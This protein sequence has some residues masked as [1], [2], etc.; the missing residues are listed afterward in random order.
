[1][2]GSEES[3]APGSLVL[4]VLCPSIPAPNRFTFDN[5]SLNTTVAEL[6]ARLSRSIQ[7]QPTANSQRLFYLGKPLLDDGATLQ[8][9]F[10]PLNGTEFSIHLVL[11]PSLPQPS[12]SVS[13]P[14]NHDP[15]PSFH[16]A[17]SGAN[18][19]Q[20]STQSPEQMGIRTRYRP[21][22]QLSQTD[23]ARALQDNAR[24]RLMEL[25]Q[26]NG[27]FP[28]HRSWD[29][30]A[31]S[32]WT[33][34][35]HLPQPPLRIP[36]P[37]VAAT[38]T[39][40]P[41]VASPTSLQPASAGEL[42]LPGEVQSRLRLL[43]QYI[44]LAEE[45][46]NCGIAPSIDH[47]IQLRT[48]LFKLLDDQQ[49]RPIP[50]RGE[51]LE[52][53]VSRVFEISSRADFARQRHLLTVQSASS[54]E[55]APMYLL[56]S[57]DGYQA[58][59]ASSF[60]SDALRPMPWANGSTSSTSGTVPN[61]QPNPE[62]AV[63]ENV[64]RQAVLNQRPMPD[65]QLGLGRNLR[66]LWLFVRLYFFCFMF[67]P[68]GSWT[69]YIYVAL[70]VVASILSETS[71]PR[72]IYDMILAPVQR[73]LEGLVHF[74]PEEELPAGTQGTEGTGDAPGTNQQ[75]GIQ[76][77][78][79]G[80]WTAG[81]HHSLRRVERSA[82][83]FIASLVP[84]VGER[85]IEVRNAAEAARNAEMARQEEERRQQ[86]EEAAATATEDQATE[87]Q[88]QAEDT[89]VSD[90]SHRTTA[91]SASPSESQPLIPQEA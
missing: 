21:S 42:Q 46:L 7:T 62:A 69:R 66:R 34:S 81:V 85:H 78:R 50:E 26:R 5:I 57:P 9:L 83:L 68:A 11:P 36:E 18:P 1:M 82:A 33:S 67:S 39:T 75:A 61:A 4:H 55:T 43:K 2:S 37:S 10:G 79:Q 29:S 91:G 63:M 71:V 70:A 60:A 45:Q 90:W 65:G 41:F 23:L 53:L 51:R 14:S 3:S 27:G 89:A 16:T 19:P 80:N 73:H 30:T 76:N 24:R 88:P 58:V 86:Q 31:S 22:D 47:V 77:G 6:K 32:V 52:P 25:N 28:Q 38:Y 74:A 40:A 20:Y 13:S 84:G 49:K 87:E 64:V 44:S 48:H 56:S 59:V 72:R 12:N 17:T 15:L 8:S 35:R 54:G